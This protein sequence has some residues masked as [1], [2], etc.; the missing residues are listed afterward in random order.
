M[1]AA[2]A[3]QCV[4]QTVR[5]V[6]FTSA[7]ITEAYLSWL[8]NKRLMRFSRQRL[9]HHTRESSERYLAGFEDSPSRFWAVERLD[10]LHVG[11]M[12]LH[13][14]PHHNTGDLGIAIGHPSKGAGKEAWGLALDY[15][16]TVLGLRKITAGTVLLNKAMLGVFKHWKMVFE[17]TQRQQEIIEGQAVDVLFYGMLRGEWETRRLEQKC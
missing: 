9:V 16:F 3:G 17:G 4:G 14:D 2:A 15:G 13:V 7:H 8:N 1:D 12:T 6:P 11:T 5:L 10:G